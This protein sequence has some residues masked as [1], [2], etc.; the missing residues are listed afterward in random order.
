MSL[1]TTDEPV[2]LT[3][4]GSAAL[5]LT[6]DQARILQRLVREKVCVLP[7][8]GAAEWHLKASHYVGTIVTPDV[9]ILITPKVNTANLFYLLE[10]SGSP[11]DIGPA[12]FDYG[13]T[14]DLIPSFATFYARHLEKALAHGIPRAYREIQETVPGIRGRID[15]PA[16]MRLAGL[17]LPAE[18]S[19]DEFT[20]DIRLNRILRAAAVRLLRLSGVTVPTRLAL[21]RLAAALG[22]SGSLMPGDLR[23]PTVFNRLN[24]HCRPAEQLARLALG[25]E[26]LLNA[27]GGAS[28][29]VFLIDMNKAFESFVAARL[30]SYLT[31]RLTVRPQRTAKFD[32]DESISIVPDL[33][34]ERRPGSI[35]YVADTK[36]K[37]TADGY[38]READYYQIL[39]Y[40]AALGVPEGMLIYCQRDGDT[41]PREIQVQKLRKRLISWPL[42][43]GGTP[44]DIEQQ[45]RSLADEIQHRAA[46][47]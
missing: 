1:K 29:G 42:N 35:A 44:A 31:G 9:R 17:P 28:A 22:E 13:K 24:E 34:F 20:A 37:I 3:E 21:Q 41:P 23:T 47:K 5:Q 19:F 7:G 12:V 25:N 36:Y 11:V 38:G 43:L 32:I 30:D 33:V 40:T 15:L 14:R 27:V 2:V 46:E 18:C 39:A 16:Q 45:L 26:T 8:G 6:A 10:A 4:Y